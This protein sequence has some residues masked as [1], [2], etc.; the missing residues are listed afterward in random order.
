MLRYSKVYVLHG[1]DPVQWVT[2]LS[3]GK[4]GPRREANPS[5]LLVP[6]S[7]KSSAIPVFPLWTVRLVQ[8]QFMY[9]DALYLTFYIVVTLNIYILNGH[10]VS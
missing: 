4:E 9:K 3:R 6:W 1:S 10:A 2:G 7:R 5:S 8:S